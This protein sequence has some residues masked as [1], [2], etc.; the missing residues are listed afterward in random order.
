MCLLI[1]SL[2]RLRAQLVRLLVAQTNKLKS[3]ADRKSALSAFYEEIIQ[4]LINGVGPKTHP[5]IQTELAF[6]KGMEE[7]ARRG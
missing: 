1:R 6:F 4:E 3:P 7:E 5:R 2:T